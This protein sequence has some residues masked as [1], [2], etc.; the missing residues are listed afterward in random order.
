MFQHILIATDGSELAERAA[1]QGIAL[2]QRLKAKITVVH[3]TDPWV[4]VVAGDA[5][6]GFPSRDYDESAAKAAAA[7]L[8]RA[9]DKAKAAD[10][11][12]TLVHMKD[13]F[14]ADGILAAAKEHGCDLIVMGSHG[15]RGLAKL[16]LGSVATRVLTLS[17]VP[18]LI[19]R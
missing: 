3:A 8:A 18:V 19:C 10:V 4:A 15:R 2:A 16:L 7:I 14:S 6:I 11:P 1:S 17:P 12:C 13:S 5:A 9:A